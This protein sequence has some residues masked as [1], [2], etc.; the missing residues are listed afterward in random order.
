ME[1]WYLRIV[2]LLVKIAGRYSNEG[3]ADILF[4]TFCDFVSKNCLGMLDKICGHMLLCPAP[5]PGTQ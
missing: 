5:H 4:G 2:F 1:L 3:L